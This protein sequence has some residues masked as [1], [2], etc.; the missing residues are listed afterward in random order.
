MR[1]KKS[2]IILEVKKKICI[3]RDGNL[4]FVKMNDENAKFTLDETKS[5]FLFVLD[6]IKTSKY[7]MFWSCILH[8]SRGLSEKISELLNGG[9]LGPLGSGDPL[10]RDT[11]SSSSLDLSYDCL[12]NYDQPEEREFK[13][14]E[15]MF[16]N[17]FSSVKISSILSAKILL[18]G[19]FVNIIVR[20]SNISLRFHPDRSELYPCQIVLQNNDD[21]DLCK[22]IKKEIAILA[23]S[24]NINAKKWG[25]DVDCEKGSPFL[26]S[27]EEI[28]NSSS[29]KNIEE[30][31][32][33]LLSGEEQLDQW[34]KEF[35]E[36]ALD[37]E[38]GEI[39]KNEKTTKKQSNKK[40]STKKKT[41]GR[42]N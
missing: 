5:V 16:K 31:D 4:N 36:Y 14:F 30:D 39:V 20:E 19:L 26:K 11:D 6:L 1:K 32:G 2:D 13:D 3:C 22:K 40:K 33:L 29:E 35:G 27:V 37:L 34:N 12:N 38:T 42:K 21:I 23:V 25:F 18:D 7:K 41:D 17:I 24:N 9:D 8:E 10:A 28:L 15:G